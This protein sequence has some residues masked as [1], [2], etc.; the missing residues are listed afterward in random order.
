MNLA[1]SANAIRYSLAESDRGLRIHSES[2]VRLDEKRGRGVTPEHLYRGRS[3]RRHIRTHV[4]AQIADPRAAVQ[5]V[6]QHAGATPSR[7]NL[8]SLLGWRAS[9][10]SPIA[11]GASRLPIN[12][13][14]SAES[15]PSKIA[16]PA[17]VRIAR[18]TASRSKTEDTPAM[19]CTTLPP[20]RTLR[21][22]TRSRPFRRK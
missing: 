13:F 4:L 3:D 21:G 17:I 18:N 5:L 8:T 9:P 19:S 22:P 7:S 12:W 14:K 6:E 1:V 10:A 20:S 11:I 16:S 2:L 15:A